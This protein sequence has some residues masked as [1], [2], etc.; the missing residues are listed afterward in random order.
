VPSEQAREIALNALSQGKQVT[1]DYIIT[2]LTITVVE[3]D[4]AKQQYTLPLK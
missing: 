3:K 1:L 2:Q 4:G